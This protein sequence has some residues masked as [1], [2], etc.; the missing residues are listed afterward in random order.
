M[1]EW[2]AVPDLIR[3][4]DFFRVA[5]PVRDDAGAV[6]PQDAVRALVGHCRAM[7]LWITVWDANGRACYVDEEGSSVW[8]MLWKH[9]P[10]VRDA[11]SAAAACV[12]KDN[13]PGAGGPWGRALGLTGIPVRHRGRAI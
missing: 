12:I 6:L 9:A 3:P 2:P 13:N 10:L 11:L 5:A 8:T 7:S 1:Q 4:A